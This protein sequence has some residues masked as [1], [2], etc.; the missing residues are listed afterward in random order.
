MINIITFALP[1]LLDL[2]SS[3]SGWFGGL[4]FINEASE[5]LFNRSLKAVHTNVRVLAIV[6]VFLAQAETFYSR[7]QQPP[8]IDIAHFDPVVRADQNWQVVVKDRNN[9]GFELRLQINSQNLRVEMTN[10]AGEDSTN[11]RRWVRVE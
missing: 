4:L 1:Y 2:L 3:W 10:A 8:S 9:A 5:R 11:E 7:R 6:L